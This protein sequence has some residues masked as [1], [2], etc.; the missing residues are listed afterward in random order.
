MWFMTEFTPESLSQIMI[1]DLYIGEDIIRKSCIANNVH[2]AVTGSYF[3]D[4]HVIYYGAIDKELKE[5]FN[6]D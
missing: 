2:Y 6:Y 5:K 3:K 1:K 4:A